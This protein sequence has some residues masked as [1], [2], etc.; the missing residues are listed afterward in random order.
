MR[1]PE[2]ER[3]LNDERF[4]RRFTKYWLRFLIQTWLPLLIVTL[5]LFWVSESSWTLEVIAL[6]LIAEFLVCNALAWYWG[7]QRAC[8]DV[9]TLQQNYR[10]PAAF[11]FD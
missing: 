10:P 5:L 1:H 3:K 6:L 2:L 7:V 8:K 9:R 4:R 11:P